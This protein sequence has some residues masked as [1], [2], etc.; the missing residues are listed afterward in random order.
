MLG[1]VS[2]KALVTGSMR[3]VASSSNAG[4]TVAYAGRVPVRVRGPVQLGDY[5]VASGLEDGTGVSIF[6]ASACLENPSTFCWL[7]RNDTD[8]SC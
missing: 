1:V 5:I 8:K 2:R 7:V 3:D 4:D 6:E